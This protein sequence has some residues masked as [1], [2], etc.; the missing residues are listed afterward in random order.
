MLLILLFQV[1]TSTT[2]VVH[3]EAALCTAS[4][5]IVKDLGSIARSTALTG[6]SATHAMRLRATKVPA[7]AKDYVDKT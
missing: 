4:Y 2:M 3:T 5:R 7:K 6:N 1:V